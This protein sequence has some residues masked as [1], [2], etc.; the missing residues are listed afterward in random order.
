MANYIAK[1]RSNYFRVKDREAFN[2]FCEE[3]DLEAFEDCQSGQVG[4]LC[5]GN[6][7]PGANIRRSDGI[8]EEREFFSVLATHLKRGSVAIV[9]EVGSEEFRYLAGEGIAVNST[10]R[11]VSIDLGSEIHRLAKR[12]TS[13]KITPCQY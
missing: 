9:M 4:F 8:I 13:C 12:L 3:N 1:C 11:T 5:Y 10:G 7:P 6:V 2:R